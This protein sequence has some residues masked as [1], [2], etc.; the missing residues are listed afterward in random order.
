MTGKSSTARKKRPVVGI[1]IVLLLF[2]VPGLLFFV[3]PVGITAYDDSHRIPIT[4]T[5]RSA[6]TGTESSGS[7]KGG[8]A[9]GPQVVVVTEQCGK[10]LLQDGIN[11]SN[12]GAVAK[13]ITD[14]ER[15]RFSVGEAA[16]R[17]RAQIAFFGVS[18]TAYGFTVVDGS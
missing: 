8:G 2:V 16:Y 12:A 14:A 4:C 1:A 18:P 5:I 11:S 17:L 10:I 15:V 6:V 7:F 13:E 9:S 3:I